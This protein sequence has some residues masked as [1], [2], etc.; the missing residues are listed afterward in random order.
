MMNTGDRFV[1]SESGLITT[2]ACDRRG[3]P[4]YALEGAIFV[5]GAAIQWLRDSLQV[6]AAA[7]DTERI[8]DA[9]SDTAGVYV[10]PAF[11]GLGAP[12]WN[13]EARGAI[14]GITRATTMNH[15]IRAT[16]ESLAYQTFDLLSIMEKE[17][18]IP[19]PGL[20]VD[21]GA[22]ANDF[23]MQFQADVAGIDI[24]RPEIIETTSLG[25]A[26]LAGLGCGFWRDFDAVRTSWQ[27]NRVFRP[28]L[29]REQADRLHAGWQRAVRSVLVT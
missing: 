5:A 24:L 11:V 26:F 2:L 16:V 27:M 28:Q 19:I 12:H 7:A 29:S 17:A 9:T 8:C 6:I 22:C 4:A 23:L 10:V 18:A 14:T 20:K 1:P 3:E 21:G 15:I 13:Q 25:A